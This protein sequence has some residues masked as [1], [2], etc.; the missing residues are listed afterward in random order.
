MMRKSLKI[1]EMKI[2]NAAKLSP[3]QKSGIFYNEQFRFLQTP[4]RMPDFIL[5]SS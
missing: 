5:H 4:H 3:E 2:F 1:T